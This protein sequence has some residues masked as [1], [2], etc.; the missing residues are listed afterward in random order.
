MASNISVALQLDTRKF[1]SSVKKSEQQVKQ[2]SS[3]GS[4]NLKKLGAA[5]A[6][7]GGAAL[8][9]N[10]VSIGQTFQDLRTSLTAVTGSAEQGEAAFSNLTTLA[11][12]TQFS[13]EELVQSFI[14]LKG[15]GINPTNDL[16]LTFANTASIAQDQTGVLTALTE[17][18]SRAISKGKLELEDFNKIEERQVGIFKILRKEFNMSIEDIQKLAKTASGQE[19]LFAGITKALNDAYGGNLAIKLKNSSIAFSN[20]GIAIRSLADASFTELGLDDTTAIDTLT[21][22]INRL[23]KNTDGLGAIFDGIGKAVYAIGTIFIAFKAISMKAFGPIVAIADKLKNSI[24]GLGRVFKDLGF[25]FKLFRAGPMSAAALAVVLGAVGASASAVAVAIGSLVLALDGVLSIFGLGFI[26]Y[27]KM[28]ESLGLVGKEAKK[29]KKELEELAR[30]NFVG[31]PT[32]L[33]DADQYNK[34]TD[35]DTLFDMET[36]LP[37]DMLDD[38]GKMIDRSSGKLPAYNNL[39]DTFNRLFSDPKTIE[40]MEERKKALDDLTSSYAHLFEPVKA[41]DDAIAD[42]IEDKAEYNALQAEILKL[43]DLGLLSAEQAA[44]KQRELDK[45]FGKTAGMQSFIDTLSS[46]TT[47][48]SDDLA[49]ALLSGK[50]AMD[51]FKSFF[52]TMVQQLVADALKLLFIIPILEYLGFSAPGGSITGLNGKGLMANLGFKQ[53]G[54][55]GGNLMPNRPVLVGENGPEVF[56]PASSGSLQ[57]NGVGQNVTYNISAIDIQSFQSMIARDKSFI[58]AVVTKA[59]NDLPSGR[60]F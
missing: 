53:T 3:T 48:L 20:L 43:Q 35:N 23:A 16:L 28:A 9:K 17:L 34:L 38:F 32:A 29:T 51:S 36:Q 5:F 57:A 54:A 37:L 30:L 55:G 42:G 27:R 25:A 45:E 46:A 12:Q 49:T 11:T 52:K 47:A 1:D 10:I 59:G 21:K 7:L 6:A 33:F 60:R 50:S 8:I 18:Y 13:V 4:A 56:R 41:L 24:G 26:P 2:F 58:H 40:E 19:K 14:R 15:S 44:E 22:A 39:M 31:P